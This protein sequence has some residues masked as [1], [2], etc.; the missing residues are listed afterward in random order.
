MQNPKYG[1]KKKNDPFTEQKQTHKHRKLM[2][3]KGEGGCQIKTG[4]N[5]FTWLY[6]REINN[7]VLLYRTENY[8]QYIVITYKGIWKRISIYKC[9]AFL[10]AQMVKN[11]PAVQQ[12]WDWSLG[13]EDSLEK[14]TATQSSIPAWRIPWTEEPGGLW[15]VASQ[16]WTWLSD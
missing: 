4:I 8:I 3:T 16:S 12:T 9:R 2:V 13:Q 14:Q 6:V 10:V 5:R 1:K 7:K 11:L 15:S